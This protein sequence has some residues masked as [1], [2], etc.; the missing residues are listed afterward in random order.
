VRVANQAP[1]LPKERPLTPGEG[2]HY[3]LMFPRE[4]N[5]SREAAEQF[6]G[7]RPR[8]PV[9]YHISRPD[10]PVGRTGWTYSGGTWRSTCR[11]AP[12]RAEGGSEAA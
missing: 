8:P 3:L 9:H 7:L 12:S 1:L 6:L 2:L 11:I 5:F 10:L 4:P